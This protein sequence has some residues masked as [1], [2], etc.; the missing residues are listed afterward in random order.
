MGL[1]IWT[2]LS[3]INA[4]WAVGPFYYCTV[5]SASLFLLFVQ[6]VYIH[7]SMGICHACYIL[8]C[9]FTRLLLSRSVCL[10]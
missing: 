2:D 7:P 1:A 10:H 4:T 6:V 9:I 5:V 3:C 8:F